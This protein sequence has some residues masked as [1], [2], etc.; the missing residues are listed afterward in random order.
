MS[1]LDAI[2]ESEVH[3]FSMVDDYLQINFTNGSILNIYNPYI[4]TSGNLSELDG[5]KLSAVLESSSKIELNFSGFLNVSIDMRSEAYNGP[6]A[7][8]LIRVDYPTVI[9]S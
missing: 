5:K 8:Q 4:V 3:S 9:W 2:L 1:A 7:M 6:E